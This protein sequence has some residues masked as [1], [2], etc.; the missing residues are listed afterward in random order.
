MER[1]KQ[2][3]LL[4]LKNEF[5]TLLAQILPGYLRIVDA[6]VREKYGVRAIDLLFNNPSKLYESLK[7]HYG[8]E[9]S[10]EM[11]LFEVFL[12]PL[13]RLLGYRIT[14]HE[15]L[16]EIRSGKDKEVVLKI[17]NTYLD[18]KAS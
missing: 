17:L 15:L 6:M 1:G 14:E 12:R 8:D 5:S 16:Q 7:E 9:V 10:A 2:R 11:V 4:A 18:R 13:A 3:M